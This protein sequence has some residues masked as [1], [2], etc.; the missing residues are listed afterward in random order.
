LRKSELLPAQFVVFALQAFDRD[1]IAACGLNKLSRKK[2]HPLERVE[3]RGNSLT[4]RRKCVEMRVGHEQSESEEGK[5]R[6]PHPRRRTLFEKRRRLIFHGR[7]RSVSAD[8]VPVQG[9]SRIAAFAAAASLFGRRSGD[10]FRHRASP[11]GECTA[12]IEPARL[13]RG[14]Y[15]EMKIVPS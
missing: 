12:E 14:R 4:D 9:S 2:S 8:H 13:R 1:E 15:S 10:L 11:R 6:E 5:E 7:W 3:H